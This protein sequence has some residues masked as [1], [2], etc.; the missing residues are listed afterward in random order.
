MRAATGVASSRGYSKCS[1]IT[2]KLI[3]VRADF[4]ANLDWRSTTVEKHAK[5]CRRTLVALV[6]SD[7]W[8]RN[9]RAI[10]A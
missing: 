8:W 2:P 5:H 7:I 4:D 9:H 10:I 1:R 3:A 6:I